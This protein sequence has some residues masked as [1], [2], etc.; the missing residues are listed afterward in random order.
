VEPKAPQRPVPQRPR[1]R[2]WT[3]LAQDAHMVAAPLDALLPTPVDGYHAQ[4]AA[5]LLPLLQLLA[6]LL[7]LSNEFGQPRRR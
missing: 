5:A 1:Q 7:D 4:A 6:D 2:P 3:L